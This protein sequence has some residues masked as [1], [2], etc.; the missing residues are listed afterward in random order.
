[1]IRIKRQRIQTKEC[2]HGIQ[3]QHFIHFFKTCFSV[4][5]VADLSVL[6]FDLE[7]LCLR[8]VCVFVLL[9]EVAIDLD[10]LVSALVLEELDGGFSSLSVL[11]PVWPDLVLGPDV[12]H[13]N[14]DRDDILK[15]HAL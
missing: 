2:K 1:M 7:W 13:V 3:Q 5:H 15:S 4:L 12:N 11:L 10:L 14:S 9:I 6:V 8:L